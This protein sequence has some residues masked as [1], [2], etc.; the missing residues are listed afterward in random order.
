MMLIKTLLLV[1]IKENPKNIQ[2]KN[3]FRKKAGKTMRR[4]SDAGVFLFC[5]NDQIDE[6]VSKNHLN[7]QHLFVRKLSLQSLNDQNHDKLKRII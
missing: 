3:L 4:N 2:L 1:I 6:K 7:Y 5:L